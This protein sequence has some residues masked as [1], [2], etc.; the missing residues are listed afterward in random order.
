MRHI[1]DEVLGGREKYP[2]TVERYEA[3]RLRVQDPTTAPEDIIERLHQITYV[4]PPW[5][6]EDR[7]DLQV[8]INEWCEAYLIATDVIPPKLRGCDDE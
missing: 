6:V 2:L 1:Q 3:I 8:T 4:E 7:D 5:E